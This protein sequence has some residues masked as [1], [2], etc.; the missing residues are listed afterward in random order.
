MRDNKYYVK[1]VAY[2]LVDGRFLVLQPPHIGRNVM[3]LL[4]SAA[5]CCLSRTV[6][7]TAAP[8]LC[9]GGEIGYMPRWS[10]SRRGRGWVPGSYG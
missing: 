3:G 10:L 5:F 7:C 2:A 1:E 4:F 8:P 6:T 9:I